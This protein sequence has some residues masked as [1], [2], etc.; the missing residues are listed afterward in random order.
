MDVVSRLV[1]SVWYS[2]MDVFVG[3][4]LFSIVLFV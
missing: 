4:D 1:G 2:C 3:L